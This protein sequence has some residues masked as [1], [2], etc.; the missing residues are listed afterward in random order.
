VIAHVYEAYGHD[1]VAMISTHATLGPRS[2]FREAAK[3]LGVPLPRVNALAKRVPR[4]LDASALEKVLRARRAGRAAR[5]R[6][7]MSGRWSVRRRP[8]PAP[9]AGP[10]WA[11]T[12]SA[13]SSR[14]RASPRRSGSRH[15]SRARRGISPCTAA[16]S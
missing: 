4:D 8:V 6:R 10:A 1:R 7:P 11:R 12:T 5:R 13:P 3:A 9:V 2:A 16:G 14:T 15:G